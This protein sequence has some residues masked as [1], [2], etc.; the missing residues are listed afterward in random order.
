MNKKQVAFDFIELTKTSYLYE[1]STFFFPK[2]S[3]D[4]KA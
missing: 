3:Y 2:S 1:K 4:I